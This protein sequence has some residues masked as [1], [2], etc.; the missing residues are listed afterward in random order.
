MRLSFPN[1]NVYQSNDFSKLEK[2]SGY[3]QVFYRGA[4]RNFI[5][6]N[7]EERVADL[8]CKEFGFPSGELTILD[9]GMV[10]NL[11]YKTSVSIYCKK[12]A[13]KLRYCKIGY[14]IKKVER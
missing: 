9:K 4:W 8:I 11:A 3:P 6:F 5:L 2:I 1:K 14:G 13:A 10:K 12:N 7:V